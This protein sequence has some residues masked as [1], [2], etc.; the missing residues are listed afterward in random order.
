MLIDLDFLCFAFAFWVDFSW[1]NFGWVDF[2]WVDF[3]C[4]DFGWVDFG[5]WILGWVDFGR[6][7]TSRWKTAGGFQLSA[8]GITT[9]GILVR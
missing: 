3:G 4:V 2:G 9:D 7:K 1:V 5:G 8:E 6:W